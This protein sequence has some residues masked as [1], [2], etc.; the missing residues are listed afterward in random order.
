MAT[1]AIDASRCGHG[2]GLV[3]PS[4]KKLSGRLTPRGLAMLGA[5]ARPPAAAER[6]RALARRNAGPAMAAGAAAAADVAELYARAAAAASQSPQSAQPLAGGGGGVQA[7]TARGAQPSPRR[8]SAAAAV[9]SNASGACAT[10][11]GSAARPRRNASGGAT[12]RQQYRP[13][14]A[15]LRPPSPVLTA[16][17]QQALQQAAAAAAIV[18]AAEAATVATARS[19]SRSRQPQTPRYADVATHLANLTH[20]SA[21]PRK[22]SASSMGTPSPR[23]PGMRSERDAGV[24]RRDGPSQERSA[25][26]DGVSQE[27]V[28]TTPRGP[29]SRPSSGS[30][31]APRTDSP[32]C[33]A[34]GATRPVA[35]NHDSVAVDRAPCAHANPDIMSKELANAPC[36]PTHGIGEV[37]HECA[38]AE[39]ESDVS[40]IPR[41]PPPCPANLRRPR[42]RPGATARAGESAT[43]GADAGGGAHVQETRQVADM[44]LRMAR[45]LLLTFPCARPDTPSAVAAPIQNEGDAVKETGSH[46]QDVTHLMRKLDESATYL[47]D[48]ADN[49]SSPN[50]DD[51]VNV[52]T[53]HKSGSRADDGHGGGGEEGAAESNSEPGASCGRLPPR[54]RN[55]FLCLGDM[56]NESVT[57]LEPASDSEPGTPK[58]EPA[59]HGMEE[60]DGSDSDGEQYRKQGMKCISRQQRAPGIIDDMPKCLSW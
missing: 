42:P 32:R 8:S 47:G 37:S 5:M 41:P 29:P 58:A 23:R 18:A 28:A 11:V 49:A 35:D 60:D 33:A 19:C 7:R 40:H 2:D 1:M 34:K 20:E 31:G 46:N 44:W 16:S 51:A 43:A 17:G 10:A 52:A 22:P 38:H 45:I 36:A 53:L 14:S 15:G 9:A 3:L 59:I 57:W 30:R 25:R 50:A 55:G 24:R 4:G 56:M 27:R 21:A 6:E 12:P 26:R 13:T 54:F 39:Q 48:D